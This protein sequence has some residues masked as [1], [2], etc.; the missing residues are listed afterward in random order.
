MLSKLWSYSSDKYP[1]TGR[2][3]SWQNALGK[4]GLFSEMAANEEEFFGRLFNLSTPKGMEFTLVSSTKQLI[5]AK[6]ENKSDG[7]WVAFP[8]EGRTTIRENERSYDVVPGD[9]VFG[10]LG[11]KTALT[12]H[13]GFRQLF[14]TIPNVA[15]NSR[16]ISPLPSH[17]IHISGHSGPGHS[18]AALLVSVSETIEKMNEDQIRPLEMAIPEFIIAALFPEADTRT[19]GGSAGVK[20]SLLH[21]VCQSIEV[22]LSNPELSLNYVAEQQRLAPRYLQKL[23]ESVDQSFSRYIRSRRLEHCREDLESPIHTQLSISEISL[24]WGF[25]DSAYFSRSFRDQF[26]MSASAYRKQA[27]DE[28]GLEQDRSI[29]RGWPKSNQVNGALS[30]V[31][32]HRDRKVDR[33]FEC[34]RGCPKMGRET[35]ENGAEH[36][37]PA[38]MNTVHWG[39]F[40]SRLPPVLRIKSGETLRIETL[41]HH[42]YDDYERMIKGDAGAE[43]V[44][45]WTADQKNI[46]RRGA[47]PMD[48]SIY[49][50]GAGEG[51]G[52]HICTGPV[53]IEDAMPGDVL[54]IRI[55]DIET[56]KNESEEFKGRSFGAN[57]TSWWGFHFDDFL[58]QPA[59]REVITL[60][61]IDDHEAAN[62][63]K[64]VYS[65]RWTPQTDPF[66][67]VH[68]RWDY[69]GVPVDHRKTERNFDVLKD[70]EVPIRLHFGTIGLAPNHPGLIDSVPPSNTGGNIDNWRAGKGS[71]LFLPVEVAGG[72]FSVGGPHASQGDS[73]VGGTA[74]ECSLTG[75]FQIVL[76]KKTSLSGQVF[77]LDYPVIETEDEWVILGFCHPNYLKELGKNAQSDVY[78]DPSIDRAMRDAFRKA[79]RFLMASQSLTEDEAISLLS[80]SVDF[81]ITQVVDGNL[82]VHAIIPK[83]LFSKRR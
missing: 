17:M 54:E 35:D 52:V 19:L 2:L 83:S 57:A 73:A 23:F 1:R 13:S 44:F 15:F 5:C 79:R 40:D 71:T 81:G 80:V 22:Q 56:R 51:F 53:Y 74:I 21:R 47:G 11:S 62:I 65:F 64:A 75:V 48:A 25:N 18:L 37:L 55:L 43:S 16:L 33:P 69:P 7:V 72:L 32:K 68:K 66:G 39:Y 78:R 29:N 76:H 42:A 58:T 34:Q 50:R 10:A 41:T 61:E 12:L 63:A 67:V 70:V 9:I 77:D 82:G 14:I 24:R 36:Y 60:Y 59:S 30:S 27:R 4:L 8:L 49:G 6:K 31:L 26:D 38:N 20:A 46:D 3:P 45:K 28:G